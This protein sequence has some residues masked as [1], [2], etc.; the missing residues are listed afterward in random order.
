MQSRCLLKMTVIIFGYL[1]YC[2]DDDY[3]YLTKMI[4]FILFLFGF[5]MMMMMIKCLFRKDDSDYFVPF[6]DLL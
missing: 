1:D 5:I 3:V 6:L 4:A 2:D